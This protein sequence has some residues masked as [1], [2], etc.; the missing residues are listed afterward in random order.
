MPKRKKA[1]TLTWTATFVCLSDRNQK[2]VPT[3]SEKSVLYKAGLGV[4]RIQLDSDCT[5]EDMC[6]VLESNFQQLQHAG[7]YEFMKCKQNCRD[8]VQIDCVWTPYHIK[9]NLGSQMKIYLRPVQNN[10][11]TTPLLDNLQDECIPK[12]KCKHCRQLINVRD[13]RAHL[14]ICE[15]DVKNNSDSDVR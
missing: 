9:S 15:I 6:K 8:L 3:S 11:D 4:K 14:Q 13:L 2:K 12:E 1:R 10:L 7:G 5:Y